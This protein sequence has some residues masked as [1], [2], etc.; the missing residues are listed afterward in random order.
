[1]RALEIAQEYLA[2]VVGEHRMTSKQDECGS[3]RDGMKAPLRVW[4]VYSHMA[5]QGR[6]TM[7][8][9]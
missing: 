7:A 1:M 9:F 4:S 3:Q 6:L 5:S 2:L 8:V